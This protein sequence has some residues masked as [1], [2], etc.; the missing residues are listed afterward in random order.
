MKYAA[1]VLEDG[2]V[3]TG[4]GFGASRKAAGEVVF[5]T[6]MVGYVQSITDPSYR[7]EIL[8]QTYPLVGNYGVSPLEFESE[9][10][11]ISGYIVSEQCEHPSH[12]SSRMSLDTWLER[13]GVPGISGIDTREL[14]KALRTKGTML[15]ILE[16]GPDPPDMKNLLDEVQSVE[17]PNTRDLVDEVTVREPLVYPAAPDAFMNPKPGIAL[18]EYFDNLSKNPS[19]GLRIAV[20][21][22]GVK[23]GIIQ[24]IQIRG[25]DVIR[26][27]AAFQEDDLLALEPDGVVISNG[28]GDPKKAGYLS[29]TLKKIIGE[30]IPVFGI[31]LGNQILALAMGCDT[32]KLKFGHRG[33]NHPVLSRSD[34]RSYITS[35]NHGFAV[36]PES[37]EK[38]DLQITYTNGNDETVEGIEHRE[39]PVSAVQFHPEARPGP[40]DTGFLFDDFLGRIKRK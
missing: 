13:N 29:G 12:H 18:I 38:S 17:D 24:S 7:G 6:G 9:G 37:V 1:L 25:A 20:M 11:Q 30:K 8:C 10:P 34:G 28:P 35:Q 2:S 4:R 36:D 5:N 21:D 23:R 27:P 3:W 19:G 15:G 14:T 40:L 31:C 39:L 26:V 22:C 32:Y 33:Q 16:V